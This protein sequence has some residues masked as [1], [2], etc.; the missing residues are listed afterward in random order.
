M[1]TEV[2]EVAGSHVRRSRA[3]AKEDLHLHRNSNKD[4]MIE[5]T[6]TAMTR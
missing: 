2:V 4:M 6:E 5:S 3:E 1:N